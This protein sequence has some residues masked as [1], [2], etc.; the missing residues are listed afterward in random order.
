[1]RA[2]LSPVDVAIAE[3]RHLLGS[4]ATDAASVRE[5]HGYGES[6]HTPAPPDVVCF[7]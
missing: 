7:P 4:R 5:H 6:Y 1:M 2:G 3:L